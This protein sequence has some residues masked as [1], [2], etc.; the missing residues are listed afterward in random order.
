MTVPTGDTFQLTFDRDTWSLPLLAGLVEMPGGDPDQ[1]PAALLVY[2]KPDADNPRKVSAIGV[3]TDSTGLAQV[4]DATHKP[5]NGFVMRTVATELLEPCIKFAMSALTTMNHV[6]ILYVH[7]NDAEE[8]SG[9]SI[10]LISDDTEI[11]FYNPDNGRFDIDQD[12]WN[13]GDNPLHVLGIRGTDIDNGRNDDRNW[14]TDGSI[15]VEFTEV[16]VRST[17]LDALVSVRFLRLTKS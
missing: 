1:D 10:R 14:N 2:L 9:F 4:W 13:V 17:A 6:P 5:G 7:E 11:G 16:Q 15:T 3:V 12:F 8:R